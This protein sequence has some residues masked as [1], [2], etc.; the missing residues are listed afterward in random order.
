MVSVNFIFLYVGIYFFV[1]KH[2]KYSLANV[3]MRYGVTTTTAGNT[4][5]RYGV[6]ASIANISM[7]YC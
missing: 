7:R 5:I 2:L 4:A 1:Y 6:R 3:A